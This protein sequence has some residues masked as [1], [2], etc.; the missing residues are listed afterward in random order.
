MPSDDENVFK[1]IDAFVFRQTVLEMTCFHERDRKKSFGLNSLL[2]E[3][4]DDSPRI[5]LCLTVLES[6]VPLET[7]HN[8]IAVIFCIHSEMS[9]MSTL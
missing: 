7:K 6:V 9:G 5:P 8:V 3:T 4:N 2:N 1:R